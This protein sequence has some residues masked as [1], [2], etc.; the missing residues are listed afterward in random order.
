MVKTLMK[1]NVLLIDDDIDIYEGVKEMLSD[2]KFL[3]DY[4]DSYEWG[5]DSLLDSK[6]QI[7]LI[8][9]NLDNSQDR[10]Y[11]GI[12]LIKYA[13]EHNPLLKTIVLTGHSQNVKVIKDCLNAGADRWIDK[14]SI[15]STIDENDL[16]DS[17]DDVDDLKN[18][19]ENEFKAYQRELNL[20]NFVGYYVDEIGCPAFPESQKCKFYKQI[21]ATKKDNNVFFAI[22]YDES[23]SHIKSIIETKL[24]DNG[25]NPIIAGEQS[26]L[27]GY[28]LCNVCFQIRTCKFGIADV[29][30]LNKLNIF[31]ELGLMQALSKI[32][33]I[34]Y[35]EDTPNFK[36]PCDLDGLNLAA[37]SINKGLPKTLGALLDDWID[38]VAN[39]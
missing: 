29:S 35:N 11:R 4:V 28:I 39:L 30:N 25:F 16:A 34:I 12:E 23:Y 19:L 18:I 22:P 26:K 2:D 15:F 5:Q 20:H 31:Y 6:Y 32:P 38:K 14:T 7:A 37:Y 33:L 10:E 17:K 1:I 13:E 8:D 3:L 9:L 27:G 21:K 24:L 36:L